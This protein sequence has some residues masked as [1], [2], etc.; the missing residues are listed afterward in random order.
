M[1]P[2]LVAGI[3]ALGGLAQGALSHF[4]SAQQMK[5]QERMS[6]TAHQREVADLRAAGLNPLLSAGGGGAS[7][8]VGAGFDAPD[9]VG[10]AVATRRLHDELRTSQQHRENLLAE[11]EV[12][13]A[14]RELKRQEWDVNNEMKPHLI[15]SAKAGARLAERDAE[16]GTSDSGRA[17]EWIKRVTGAVTGGAGVMPLLPFGRLNPKASRLVRHE[18]RR[19]N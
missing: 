18:H 4:S 3:G 15:A 10:S 5:F 14:D 12:K 1:G 19:V 13:W 17:L 11:R 9:I 8:P 16:M 2:G 6:N 7:S